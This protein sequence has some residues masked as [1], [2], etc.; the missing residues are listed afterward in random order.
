MLISRLTQILSNTGSGIDAKYTD[1]ALSGAHVL[2]NADGGVSLLGG[3]LVISGSEIS[4]NR[5]DEGAG[6][7]VVWASAL[8]TDTVL[9]RNSAW[10]NGGAVYMSIIDEHFTLKGSTLTGNSAPS[11]AGIYV[12]GGNVQVT[13]SRILANEGEHGAAFYFDSMHNAVVSDSCIV[14]N[15]T[16]E[17]GATA[18]EL[19]SYNSYYLSAPKNWWG[20]TDG[21]SGAGQGSGDSIGEQVVFANFL[22]SQPEGCPERM[23]PRLY[24]PAL[25]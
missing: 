5:A 23:S 25:E 13:A 20:A 9:A 12:A 11:G 10:R 19:A 2:G 6:I 7:N 21:P 16:T 17:G 18:V 4:D 3:D 1:L 24:L 14:A 22:T 15:R 8:I